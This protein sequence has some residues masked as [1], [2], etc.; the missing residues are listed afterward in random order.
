VRS[1]RL[2]LA[3]RKKLVPD[4]S[5]ASDR[6]RKFFGDI[7]PLPV[8]IFRGDS[9]QMLISDHASVVTVAV[10]FRATLKHLWK[11]GNIDTR[12]AIGMG[13]VEFIPGD[14]VSEGDG[15]AFRLSGEALESM[16][17][18]VR[19]QI[20]FSDKEL[21]K[22]L[23]VVIHLVDAIVMRWTDKQAL[24]VSG[25]LRGLKQDEITKLWKPPITQQNVAKHLL[26]AKW[27]QVGSAL[28]HIKY[29]LDKL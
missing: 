10:F 22:R 2:P 21:E 5:A 20:G 24:V 23:N 29:N 25:A 14:R 11:S 3:R 12:I 9:W 8:D 27:Y 19:M 7:V 16:D 4:I 1:S 6:L 17:K 18:H 15:E 28:D 13:K 26:K